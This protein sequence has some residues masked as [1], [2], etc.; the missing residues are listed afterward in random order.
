MSEK[1]FKPLRYEVEISSPAPE[2][3][4]GLLTDLSLY[5]EITGKVEI[6]L[7]NPK[8][9]YDEG[10]ALPEKHYWHEVMPMLCGL[11]EVPGVKVTWEAEGGDYVLDPAKEPPLEE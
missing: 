7:P 10:G 3:V 5:G 6:E 4:P 1:A 2:E 11:A 8:A 9:D